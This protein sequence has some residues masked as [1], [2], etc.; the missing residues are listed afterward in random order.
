MQVLPAGLVLLQC[1]P[2]CRPLPRPRRPLMWRS[3]DSTAVRE[4]SA[5]CQACHSC[6]GMWRPCS[7]CGTVTLYWL[8]LRAACTLIFGMPQCRSLM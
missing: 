1:T 4:G 8:Q 3:L 7:L 6:Q 5:R 2:R